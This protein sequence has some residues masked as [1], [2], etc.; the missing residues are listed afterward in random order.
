MEDVAFLEFVEHS[1]DE[2]ELENEL[3][4]ENVDNAWCFIL[5]VVL[6]IELT[7]LQYFLMLILHFAP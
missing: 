4:T 6:D 7:C 2:A 3:I 1:L 5:F